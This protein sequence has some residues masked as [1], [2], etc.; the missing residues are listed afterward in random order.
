MEQMKNKLTSST[1][2]ST[3]SS[4][5]FPGSFGTPSVAPSRLSILSLRFMLS[6]GRFVCLAFTFFANHALPGDARKSEHSATPIG[7]KK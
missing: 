7:Q 3:I 6:V 5:S 2:S 1:T 4:N